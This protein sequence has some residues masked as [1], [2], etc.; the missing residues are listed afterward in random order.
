MLIWFLY[1]VEVADNLCLGLC[2]LGQELT[3]ITPDLLVEKSK[4]DC[5]LSLMKRCESILDIG[6]ISIV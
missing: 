5:L 6:P 3:D 2:L 4:C 1:P